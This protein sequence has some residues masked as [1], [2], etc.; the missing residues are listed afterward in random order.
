LLWPSFQRSCVHD[1]GSRLWTHGFA[2]VL[3]IGAVVLGGRA[4]CP[5]AA[6][7]VDPTIV[8]REEWAIR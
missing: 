8:L 7:R 5:Q 4:I 1:V 6:A 3:V 2:V